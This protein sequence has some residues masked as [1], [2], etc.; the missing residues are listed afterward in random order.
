VGSASS[1]RNDVH[2]LRSCLHQKM[3]EGVASCP[4][5]RSPSAKE[6]SAGILLAFGE[7]YV[8]SLGLGFVIRCP[9]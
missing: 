2:H 9:D 3:A 1:V 6:P 5:L 7:P 8:Q 4:H